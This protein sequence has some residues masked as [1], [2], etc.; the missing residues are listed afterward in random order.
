MF[1]KEESLRIPNYRKLYFE[2]IK[3]K[4]AKLKWK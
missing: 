4:K 2:I 3:V 1:K